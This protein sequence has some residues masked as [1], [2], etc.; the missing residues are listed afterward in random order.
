M[1]LKTH[2]NFE[3]NEE[4]T[5]MLIQEEADEV[6]KTY[7]GI[8]RLHESTNH[9][10][11]D[12]L[13]YAFE[14]AGK[15]T[16]GVKKI[17]KDVCAK[18]VV[19]KTHKRSSGHPQM[20]IPKAYSFNE[21]VSLDLKQFGELHVLWMVDTFSRFI[22]GKVIKNKGSMTIIKALEETWN[23]VIGYPSVGY[24]TDNGGEFRNKEMEEFVTKM[25]LTIKFTPAYSPWSNGLN[26]R[27]HYSA[28]QVV[29]KMMFE[30]KKMT[31]E[32]AVTRASWTHNTNV[33][34]WGHTPMTLM[35]GKSV[36]FPVITSGNK[37]IESKYESGA[38]KIHFEKGHEASKAFREAEFT[39]KMK[40]GAKARKTVFDDQTYKEGDSV[41]YQ[42][43]DQIKWDGPVTVNSHRGRDVFINANGNIKKVASCK[44]QPYSKVEED[45]PVKEDSSEKEKEVVRD[46]SK[47]VSENKHRMT[48][49][50]KDPGLKKS[51]LCLHCVDLERSERKDD[52]KTDAVAAF[53]LKVQNEECFDKEETVFVVEIPKKEHGTPEVIAAKK[54]EIENL[55]HYGT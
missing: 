11:E 33:N 6:L 19:C 18:C 26:E 21:I 36:F 29:K 28:D 16:S 24:W 25:G 30:D 12:K 2:R 55:T 49:R 40:V 37:A 27:N 44:V 22:Q 5:V 54:T 52:L 47:V 43:K 4:E 17:V 31:L 46:D 1:S 32:E 10:S 14:M 38:L 50:L 15:M 7:K 51:S 34:W 45:E 9:K 8:R 42:E 23:L 48:M 20:T 41:L 39:S 13:N 35:S 3:K 53:Y